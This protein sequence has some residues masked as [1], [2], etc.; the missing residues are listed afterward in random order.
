MTAVLA[1]AAGGCGRA[2][3][4]VQPSQPL[5]SPSGSNSIAHLPA[6]VWELLPLPDL[7]GVQLNDIAHTSRGWV[8]VGGPIPTDVGT[9]EDPPRGVVLFSADGA[10][11]VRVEAPDLV[12]A[13]DLDAVAAASDGGFVAVGSA[14]GLAASWHSADGLSWTLAE[15]AIDFGQAGLL[16]VGAVTDGF[17]AVGFVNQGGVTLPAAWRSTD[18]HHW[19]PSGPIGQESGMFRAILSTHDGMI[20]GG[21]AQSDSP[22]AATARLWFSTD[23][24]AWIPVS[25]GEPAPSGWVAGLAKV[26][27]MFV[28]VGSVNTPDAA[29]ALWLSKDAVRW[30]AVPSQAALAAIGGISEMDD[31]ASFDNAL[32]AVGGSP[33][34]GQASAWLSSDGSN[35]VQVRRENLAGHLSAVSADGATA[36]AVGYRGLAAAIWRVSVAD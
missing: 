3:G 2:P 27:S 10:D 35:W 14:R 19:A 30:Q 23:G 24:Q 33:P 9:T 5:A 1:L 16:D 15:P 29:A 34:A 32:L 11:W 31:I 20:A 26:R 8:A 36:L 22:A 4:S 13:F 12:G 18:G 6:T 28:A 25:L 7:P 17:V 21:S